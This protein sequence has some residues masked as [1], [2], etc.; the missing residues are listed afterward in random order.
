[1]SATAS[2]R[3][4][5]WITAAADRGI[6][7]GRSVRARSPE[8]QLQN[9]KDSTIQITFTGQPMPE[10]TLTA[11]LR[12]QRFPIG[13]ERLLE[14][15]ELLAAADERRRDGRHPKPQPHQVIPH[16]APAPTYQLGYSSTEISGSAAAY[17]LSGIIRIIV[18]TKQAQLLA[19]FPCPT[20]LRHNLSDAVANRK[21]D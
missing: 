14:H 10:R 13:V 20:T 17:V 6:F 21:A 12:D 8:V 1:M 2:R 19:A 16:S 4:R 3:P 7:G 11:S 18:S 5:L 15:L 9:V